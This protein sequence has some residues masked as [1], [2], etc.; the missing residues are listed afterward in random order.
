MTNKTIQ[1]LLE[2]GIINIDKPSG[3]TSHSVSDYVREQLGLKKASPLGILDPAVTGVLP[4]ALN[5]ACKLSAYLM[6]KDKTY[7]GIM[8]L[9]ED[10]ELKV[11]KEK[12]KAFVGKIKQMP[13]VRSN[14]KRAIREREIMAFQL[15]E[16]DEKDVLFMAEVEA[17]TYIRTL[18]HDLG[19]NIGGAHML[20]LRRIQAGIFTED[21]SISLYDFDKAVENYKKGS[22]DDLRTIIMPA[23]DVIAKAL[24]VLEIKKDNLD[25]ILRGK[26][27]H[28]GDLTKKISKTSGEYVAVFCGERFVEVARVV[29]EGDVVAVPDFVFN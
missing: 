15:I 23:E 27:I 9:H 10:V 19:K 3:P 18:I 16:K 5:R 7:V 2:F 20:E 1:E 25:K 22:E 26:P 13:P 8:R 17:G 21:R 28:K 14:V 11:L 29:N 12:M 4:I 24:P 6:K